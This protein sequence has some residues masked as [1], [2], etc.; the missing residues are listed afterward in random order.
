MSIRSY[1]VFNRY[2]EFFELN[3]GGLQDDSYY[4]IFSVGWFD[5]FLTYFFPIGTNDMTRGRFDTNNKLAVILA[6]TG[7]L[8]KATVALTLTLALTQTLVEG[9]CGG[10]AAVSFWPSA[11]PDS[12][13][14]DCVGVDRCPSPLG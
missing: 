9:H 6:I 13:H 11:P 4:F 2:F 1:L 8:Q 3:L 10:Q 5:V 12:R 7:P 14:R